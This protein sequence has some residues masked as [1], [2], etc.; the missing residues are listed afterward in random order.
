MAIRIKHS[1]SAEAI[2]GTAYTVG[3]GERRERDIRFAAELDLKKTSL[4]LQ[5]RGQDIQ[6]ERSRQIIGLQREE[7]GFRKEQWED[8]PARQ[9]QQ[10][11][12]QQKILQSKIRWQY[13]E[14][15]KR[16][17]AK[18][19]TGIGWLREQ[20]SAGKW[21]AEQ[22]EKAEQQL[23]RKYHSIIPLPVYDDTATAQERYDSNVVTDKI[24]GAQYRMNE[25]G[26]FEPVGISFK[27]Y[28]NLRSDVAK[29]FTTQIND[30]DSKDF[31]K[32]YTNWAA[33][34]KFV[35]DTMVR[36]TKIQGFAARAQELQRSR[37]Q[38]G[39]RPTLEQE[40]QR[41]AALEALPVMFDAIVKGQPRIGRKKKG[42]TSGDKVYGEEAY[43]NMLD[44]AVE[45][46]KREGIPPEEVKIELDKWW[47]AQYDKERGQMFQK[48]SDRAQFKS[49]A[50][51]QQLPQQLP[52]QVPQ[53][54]SAEQQVTALAKELEKSMNLS[55][56]TALRVAKKKLAYDADKLKTTAAPREEAP[57]E[58]KIA[59]EV[60]MTKLDAMARNRIQQFK[61]M[62]DIKWSWVSEKFGSETCAELKYICESG[63]EQAIANAL[64][65]L[66]II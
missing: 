35:D 30:P 14:G 61:K 44:E 59:S 27:D 5:A 16:E 10:G 17:M 32:E 43:N 8:E 41:K 37:D 28:A 46:G 18:I 40:S 50:E 38:D 39:I 13:D 48:F 57:A 63:N 11:L 42:K 33:V 1:P 54:L 53:Q 19:T 3:K 9:L 60:D 49:A 56:E 15:Q 36:F 22:A 7:L 25:R 47:D 66:G 62:K 31:G 6:A 58:R 26:G 23:W 64:R 52:Q 45:R 24:T 2:G 34:D 55:P 51:A 29:V 20:V 21:T 12:E 65:R 4:Y